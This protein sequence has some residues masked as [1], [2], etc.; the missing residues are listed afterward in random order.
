M[1]NETPSIF[2][3]KAYEKLRSPDD[4]DKYV[5]VTNPSGWVALLGCVALLVGLLVW[6]VFGTVSTNVDASCVVI[7]SGDV[8]CLISPKDIANVKQDDPIA[9]D[10]SRGYVSS[11]ATVPL[12]RA[13]VRE[14]V[15]SDY[16]TDTLMPANH[17]WAFVVQIAELDV[18]KGWV[19]DAVITTK[20]VAPLAALFDTGEV[21]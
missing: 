12:S 5:R 17:N 16:L 13:E 20:R 15:Q 19:E 2:N 9:T 1:A 3:E 6:G 21:S 7:P 11:V 10:D 4:L 14:L 18:D 8:I